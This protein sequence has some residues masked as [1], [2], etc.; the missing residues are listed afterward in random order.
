[1]AASAHAGTGPAPRKARDEPG[2]PRLWPMAQAKARARPT[3]E[4]DAPSDP[5]AAIEHAYRFHRA[6]RRAR[7][8][9]RRR[10]RY[11]QL[12]F[13]VMLCALVFLCVLVSLT[14]WNQV[15][16]LFGL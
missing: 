10:T 15:Q 8:E 6:R 2:A 7:L 13:Y 4:D 16:R 12:R 1:M 9:R 3:P 11:A 14:V 5:A